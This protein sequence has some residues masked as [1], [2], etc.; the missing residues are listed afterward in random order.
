MIGTYRAIVT[1]HMTTTNLRPADALR[2]ALKAAGF[3]ARRVSV[4]EHHSTLRVTVRDPSASLTRVKKIAA[5]F[6]SVRH[7]QATGEILS[8]GNT[9]LSCEYSDALVAPIKV[10]IAKVLDAAP[11]DEYVTVIED[12]R[13]VKVSRER[14]ATYPNEVRIEGPSFD[15]RN[16]MACG[17]YWAAERIAVAYLDTRALASADGEGSAA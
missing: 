8:G 15:Y 12:F 6:E 9:F 1:P 13:A 4:R 17:A 2:A 3:N 16:H 10:A 5:P 14:G 11:Q 7:C